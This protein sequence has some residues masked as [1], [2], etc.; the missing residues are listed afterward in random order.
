MTSGADRGAR[1][2]GV[3]NQ[4]DRNGP[5]PGGDRVE[6]LV[7]VVDRGRLRTV[8]AAYPE[9]GPLHHGAAPAQRM[10]DRGSDRDHAEHGGLHGRGRFRTRGLAAVR[11]QDDACRG[12]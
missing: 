1:P 7:Q 5:E 6:R 4:H 10:P 12:A 9:T 3:P 11:D 2:H 8:P